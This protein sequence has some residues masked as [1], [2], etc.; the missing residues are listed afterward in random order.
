M[1]NLEKK[2]REK[3]GLRMVHIGDGDALF[4]NKYGQVVPFDKDAPIV[5]LTS[6]YRY[7]GNVP[8]ENQVY[9]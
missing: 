7:Q 8:E 6:Y 5:D 1:E 4:L 3:G 9:Y 2:V